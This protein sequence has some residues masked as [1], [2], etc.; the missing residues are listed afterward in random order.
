M[1]SPSWSYFRPT[2]S[3]GRPF[4]S[5]F[6]YEAMNPSC[7]STCRTDSFSFELGTSTR[8]CPARMPLR[9]RVN[10]SL[11]ESLVFIASPRSLHNARDVAHVGVLTEANAAEAELP[12]HAPGPAAD[13]A[14]PD[15]PRHEFRLLRRLDSHR[16]RCHR[17]LLLVP[18]EA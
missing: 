13:P 14:A 8:S 17:S 3:T 10:R 2:R 1:G 15:G 12:E 6:R 11:R 18:L 4:S 5:T 7:S 9:S 16:S